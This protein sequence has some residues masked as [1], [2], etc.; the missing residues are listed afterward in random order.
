M[1]P[2]VDVIWSGVIAPLNDDDIRICEFNMHGTGGIGDLLSELRCIGALHG[3]P[4]A[5]INAF[6]LHSNA[7]ASTIMRNRKII[8]S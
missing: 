2:S 5:I 6:D 4:M 3:L 8:I 7:N 1:S